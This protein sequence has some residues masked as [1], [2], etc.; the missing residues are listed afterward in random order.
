MLN[1]PLTPDSLCT[2]QCTT[3]RSHL[4]R[5]YFIRFATIPHILN[6]TIPHTHIDIHPFY[7]VPH[8]LVLISTLMHPCI[9]LHTHTHIIMH[10]QPPFTRSHH[11]FT[12]AP[13]TC[14]N[15]CMDALTPS[16][17]RSLV[18]SFTSTPHE[19]AVGSLERWSGS[20]SSVVVVVVVGWWGRRR[21]SARWAGSSC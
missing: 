10:S 13:R 16:F 3:P 1:T 20:A 11:L 19:L 8:T 2:T 9:H 7:S 17:T 12:S 14:A 15:E 5:F 21:G 18:H 4:T 6:D